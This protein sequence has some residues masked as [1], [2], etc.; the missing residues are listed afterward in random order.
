MADALRVHVVAVYSR[1]P[2]VADFLSRALDSPLV[3][4][5]TGPKELTEFE[6]F[7]RALEPHAVVMDSSGCSEE[8]WQEV[9]QFR[10]TPPF[11]DLPMVLTTANTPAVQYFHGRLGSVVEMLSH[12]SELKELRTAVKEAIAQRGG[13]DVMPASRAS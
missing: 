11:R 6:A 8:D 1:Q 9:V 12:A 5:F 7:V 10:N 4:T 13:Q 2:V 3:A